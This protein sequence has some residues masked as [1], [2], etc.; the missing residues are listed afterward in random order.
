MI[1]TSAKRARTEGSGA[2]G[3]RS[4]GPELKKKNQSCGRFVVEFR[5]V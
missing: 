1:L 5:A 4:A 3:R 2:K